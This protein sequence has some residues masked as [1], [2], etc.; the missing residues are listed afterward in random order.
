MFDVNGKSK[1]HGFVCFTNTD[2]AAKAV[3]EMNGNLG[4]LGIKPLYVTVAQRS[5]ER[6][7]HLIAERKRIERQNEQQAMRNK[8]MGGQMVGVIIPT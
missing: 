4:L 5:E 8:A 3:M 7:Y 1:G 6:K 2:D